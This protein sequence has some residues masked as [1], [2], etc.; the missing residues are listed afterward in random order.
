MSRTKHI[1]P[2]GLNA[3]SLDAR[4]RVLVVG[5]SEEF[6]G[7][8]YL[9]AIAALRTGAESVIV[10]APEKVA[11]ALNALSPD[12]MTRKLPGAYLSRAHERAIQKQMQTADVLVLGNGAGTRTKT[13]ALMRALM[14][15]PLPKVV[16]A[17]ALKILRGNSV[18]NAILTPNEGEWKLL[19]KNNSIKKL[20]K[21]NVIVKKGPQTKILSGSRAASLRP[22]KGLAKAGTGDVLAGLCAGFLAS[23][24]SPFAAAKKACVTGTVVANILAK[25]RRGY[26]FLASD[27]VE[28]LRRS[29]RMRA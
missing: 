6:V 26:H 9:A 29:R 25:K 24:F 17:D 5:G 3:S 21:T 8:V 16:D 12:L 15:S 18:S 4:S 19:E 1:R 14:R 7:A 13:A 20:L 11:W 10:M 27:L 2:I 28:E 22:N 23:G